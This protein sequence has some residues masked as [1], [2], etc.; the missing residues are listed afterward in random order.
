M[1]QPPTSPA[2][3][4]HRQMRSRQC[5]RQQRRQFL[6]RHEISPS[7]SRVPAKRSRIALGGR[8][9]VRELD[10][11]DAAGRT[12]R[13][14]AIATASARSSVWR[15][16]PVASSVTS[17]SSAAQSQT[18]SA[19]ALPQLYLGIRSNTWPSH[20]AQVSSTARASK[21]SGG[22]TTFGG[23]QQQPSIIAGISIGTACNSAGGS[24]AHSAGQQLCVASSFVSPAD[25]CR[26]QSQHHIARASELS[27]SS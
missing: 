26:Q 20:S 21:H 7:A 1:L 13:Y 3:S 18:Q 8:E 12:R 6:Q 10:C 15:L 19:L 24:S 17:P 5:R 23:S 14:L 16:L 9:A 2:A 25:L 27:S 4:F 22:G 11:R